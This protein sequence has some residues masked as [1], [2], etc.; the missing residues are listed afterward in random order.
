MKAAGISKL[1]KSLGLVYKIPRSYG[2]D[3]YGHISSKHRSSGGHKKLYR[4]ISFKRSFF[5]I[6]GL[7]ASIEYDPFRNCRIAFVKYPSG[8]AEYIIAAEGL[9]I[10]DAVLSSNTFTGDLKPSYSMPLKVMPI[11]SIVHNIEMKPKAGGQIARSAGTFATLIDRDEKQAIL[12]L[13]S[14]ETRTVPSDCFASVGVV[15]NAEFINKKI[16][17]AGIS[18]HLGIRPR[19]RGIAKNPVDHPNGGRTNGGKIFKSVWGRIVKGL[20]TRK[21]KPSD[22]AII[23]RRNKKDN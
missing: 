10:G 9:K 2:R 4:K 14:G 21:S 23:R 15:S 8:K 18:R 20:K 1:P 19:V 16:E 17:K 22:K 13:P 11:G 6:Q 7:V 5:D 12:Q 3:S